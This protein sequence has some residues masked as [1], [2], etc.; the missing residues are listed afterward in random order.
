[1]TISDKRLSLINV[2]GPNKDDPTFY[3]NVFKSIKDI[4]NDLFI[5]CGDFKLTLNPDIDCFNYKHIN[6]PKAR[7][8]LSNV[9]EENNLFDTF[10]ELHPSQRRYTW[11]HKKHL[12]QS[13]L[14]FFLVPEN[15]VNLIKKNLKLKLGTD[16]IIQLLH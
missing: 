1:M 9:I 3:V 2:Y 15:I 7:D 6:N 13:R 10:R 8:F 16:L 11:I 14:D 4:G 5:I 12:K